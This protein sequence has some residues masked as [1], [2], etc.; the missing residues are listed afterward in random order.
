MMFGPSTKIIV[1]FGILI[2]VFLSGWERF[3]WSSKVGLHFWSGFFGGC[4]LLWAMYPLWERE[5]LRNI[6]EKESVATWSSRVFP[7][8]PLQC[9]I[10]ACQSSIPMTSD[11]ERAI[12]CVLVPWLSQSYMPICTFKQTNQKCYPIMSQA[13]LVRCSKVL[14]S[15]ANAQAANA[16][17]YGVVL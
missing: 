8:V 2:W 4:L 3:L 17:A 7:F 5:Q 9:L 16:H 15:L 1:C 6:T 10:I 11:F 13:V 14:D 12:L